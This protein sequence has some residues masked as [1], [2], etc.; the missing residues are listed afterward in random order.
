MI[1][2]ISVR[3][4]AKKGK[5]KE[6]NRDENVILVFELKLDAASQTHPGSSSATAYEQY[7]NKYIVNLS[8]HFI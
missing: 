8:Y 2:K 6:R 3:E 7:P 1:R 4:N 5:E